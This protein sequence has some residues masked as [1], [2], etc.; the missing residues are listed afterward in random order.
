MFRNPDKV[1]IQNKKFMSKLMRQFIQILKYI[2]SKQEFQ[3]P[4][5]T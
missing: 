1:S 2:Y 4:T 3:E 5:L